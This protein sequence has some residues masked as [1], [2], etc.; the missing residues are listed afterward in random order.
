MTTPAQPLNPDQKAGILMAV[1]QL[2]MLLMAFGTA[3]ERVQAAAKE[4]KEAL[5]EWAEGPKPEAPK[6]G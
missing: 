5:N 3:P 2:D 6:E 4:F 1:S